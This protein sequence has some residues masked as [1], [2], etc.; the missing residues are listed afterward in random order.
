MVLRM[1]WDGDERPSVEV[2]LGDFFGL[3]WDAFAPLSSKYV[4]S[5]PYC[6]LN[7]YWPMP[8]R[9]QARVTVENLTSRAAVLY[10]HRLRA[11]RDPDNSMYFHAT[12]HRDNPVKDGIHHVLRAAGPGKYVGTY[13]A[14]G[15]NHP[16]WWGEGEVKFYIDGDSEFPTICGTGP[17]TSSAERGT[18]RTSVG[19]STYSTPYLGLHQVI[20]PDGLYNSQQRF[21]MYRWHELDP[22]TF[23]TGLRVEL[24]GLPAGCRRVSTSCRGTTSPPRPCGTRGLPRPARTPCPY[25]RCWS[26]PIRRGRF[27]RAG[28]PDDEDRQASAPEASSCCPSTSGRTLLTPLRRPI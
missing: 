12:W 15:V 14:V 23:D 17:R 21:G 20:G 28:R 26:A 4:V 2:P 10:L 13:M 22:I 9:G 16:G 27:T 24:A 6:A 11:G 3:G 1:Y 19:Y 5:A 8:F 25:A 18:S 7:T